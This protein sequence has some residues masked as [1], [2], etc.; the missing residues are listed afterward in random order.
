MKILGIDP[1]LDGAFVL[2]EAGRPM[3]R[4]IMP[5][6]EVKKAKGKKR[7]YCEAEIVRIIK[8]C[9]PAHVFIEKQQAMPAQGGVSMFSIGLGFGILRGIVA[10]REIPFTILTAQSWQKEMFKGLAKDDTKSN[11]ALICGRLWPEIDWRASDR[12]KKA[13]SG[14]TDAALIA[15]YGWLTLG[16]NFKM[17]EVQ[18]HETTAK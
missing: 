6:I 11:S 8:H 16:D 9:N 7:E 1:G 17:P 18:H 12:C 4:A 15:R 14:A 13:H 10:A 5:V 2:L 3:F